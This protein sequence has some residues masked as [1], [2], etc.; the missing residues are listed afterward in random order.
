MKNVWAVICREPYRLFFPVGI[1]MG[2]FGAS[3]WLFYAL[4]LL[5]NYSGPFHASVQIQLYMS[6]FVVGF[7][8]TAV[9]RFSATFAAEPFEVTAFLALIL[10]IFSCVVSGHPLLAHG[11]FMVLVAGLLVFAARRFLKRSIQYP[12]VQF[13][14]IPVAVLH[15]LCGSALMILAEKGVL[16]GNFTA[17]A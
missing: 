11:F 2:I 15:G 13:I 8:T 6:S 10:A 14:W 16:G 5:P 17:S 3:H 4:G 1:C 7:L 9:P 12:P